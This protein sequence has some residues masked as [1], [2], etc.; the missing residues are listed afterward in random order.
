MNPYASQLGDQDP[1]KVLSRTPRE[2]RSLFEAI[3]PGRASQPRAPGKWSACEILVH[4]ADCEIAFAYRLRQILA[5]PHHV[6][7]P[8]DQ[9]LWAKN[10]DAYDAQS[11]LDVFS[12]VR[13][14][15]L[16]LIRSLSR[17]A[18]SKKAT[19]PE[20]GELTFGVT[21]ET[22]A[23]HDINHL[24]QMEAIAAQPAHAR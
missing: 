20:R 10:Y 15:N 13:N 4:L 7:Q 12:A 22:M 16:A 9:E 5:E 24:R 23:G 2:L 18:F 11:A 17:D 19:H 14:W 6:I 1:L 8:F 3:G 21:V